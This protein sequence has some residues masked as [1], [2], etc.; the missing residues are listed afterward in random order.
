M[1]KEVLTII[2]P[3]HN[4]RDTLAKVI[5]S[6]FE[7]L[8]QLSNCDFHFLICEDGSSDGTKELICELALRYP[9][10]NLSVEARRG[11]GKALLDGIATATG[12]YI[13]CIDGDG[14]CLAENFLLF[15]PNRNKADFL[16]GWRKPRNDSLIRLFYSKL[17]FAFHKILFFTHLHDPSCPFVLGHRDT[18]LRL[19]PNLTFLSEGFWWGFIGACIKAKKSLLE[20]K[21]KHA[22]RAGGT[23]RVFRT[24]KIPEIV[25]R[26]LI[27]LIKLRLSK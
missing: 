12:D 7:V 13:L 14:Q 26:N 24:N 5:D 23:T 27:G 18:Y 21:I 16:I 19:A 1:K 10:I 4:E 11:Y 6:W 9:V 8:K 3:V 2:L 17:F 25:L 22:K 20:I 15:W